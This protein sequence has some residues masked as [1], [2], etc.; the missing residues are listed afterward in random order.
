MNKQ[1]RVV[2]SGVTIDMETFRQNMS[3][4]GVSGS[5]VDKCIEKAPL[6]IK[7]NLSLSEARLY[8]DAIM[9][10]GGIVTIQETG[11]YTE[12]QPALKNR[13]VAL[14]QDSMLCPNCGFKQKKADVCVRCGFT[15]YPSL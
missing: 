13:T 5:T 2:F 14:Y 12:S 3:Q 8:A 4:L 10:A 9:S 7:R 6:V 15:L 1:Y 11:H